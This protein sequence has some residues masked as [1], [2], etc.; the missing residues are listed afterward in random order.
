MREDNLLAY[1]GASRCVGL[2][3]GRC[4]QFAIKGIQSLSFQHDSF[5][6]GQRSDFRQAVLREHLGKRR[7][8]PA[9]VRVHTAVTLVC[10]WRF[11]LSA[12]ARWHAP[13]AAKTSL[14]TFR[15]ILLPCA[16]WRR[17]FRTSGSA[18]TFKNISYASGMDK[19]FSIRPCLTTNAMIRGYCQRRR[20]GLRSGFVL[21]SVLHLQPMLKLWNCSGYGAGTG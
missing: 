20:M 4:L 7:H 18:P 6:L 9:S 19:V 2:N 15:F 14:Q 16:I 10:L 8:G 12:A 5:P 11:H 1:N 21:F 17:S 13:A 3:A